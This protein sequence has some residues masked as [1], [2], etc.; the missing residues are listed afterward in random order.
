MKQKRIKKKKSIFKNKLFGIFIFA[1]IFAY[2]LFYA[3][4]FLDALQIKRVQVKESDASLQS[5]IQELVSRSI[6]QKILFFSTRSIF[7]LD[8]KRIRTEV[9]KAFPD[10][11]T[12]QFAR[13]LP[14]SL[15]VT[16]QKRQEV[17]LWCK[18][19]EQCFALDNKGIVFKE[20]KPQNEFIISSSKDSIPALGELAIPQDLVSFLLNFRQKAD[21]QFVS[22]AVVS[23][24]EIQYKT[25]EGWEVYANPKE[26]LD[27]QATKL[28]A[29]LGKNPVLAK[30]ELQYI[31][32]RFGD[33]AYIKYR[34]P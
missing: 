17:A 5:N 21:V 10:V 18:T 27:W 6:Q 34:T 7:L 32:V 15:V 28:Q 2:S 26:S 14:N 12:V 25:A 24:V 13:H 23:D 16:V 33:Q 22:V 19:P 3:V 29:V 20:K 4:A 1:P 9:L 8:S 11:E 31:D 30:Q